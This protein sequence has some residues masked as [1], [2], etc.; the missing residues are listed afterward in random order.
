M[1]QRAICSAVTLRFDSHLGQKI[2]LNVGRDVSASLILKYQAAEHLA[3][4]VCIMGN[5]TGRDGNYL[6][7][8]N[9][10]KSHLC[11]LCPILSLYGLRDDKN[12]SGLTT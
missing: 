2:A 4:V 12:M 8:R 9:V 7:V 5:G 1:Q 6:K 11:V 10:M 3:A